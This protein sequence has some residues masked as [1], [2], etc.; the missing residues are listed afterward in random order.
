MTIMVVNGSVLKCSFGMTPSKILVTSQGRTISGDSI[1]TISDYLPMKNI[2]SFGMCTTQSNPAVASATAAALGTPTPAPC[3][4]N[5]AATWT[6]G[7]KNTKID[8]KPILI[9]NDMCT[10][11]YGGVITINSIPQ[12][13]SKTL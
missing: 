3:I 7:S 4:P 2:Q 8:N 6:P 10:C 5:I 1:A 9:K 11:I 12:F 13:K